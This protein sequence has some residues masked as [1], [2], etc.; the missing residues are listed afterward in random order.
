MSR[1]PATPFPETAADE[2]DTLAAAR[3]G[4]RD[5]QDA[6]LRRHEPW[7]F[8]LA[9]RMVWQRETAEDATQ[10]ILLRAARG[11]PSFSG[12]STFRTWLYRIAVNHLLDVRQSELELRRAT[13]ADFAS[14]LVECAD[15]D[16]PDPST[17]PIDHALLVE[18]A[19][20]GCMT[21]MLMCLDRR[22][23]L[24]FVLGEVFGVDSATGGE[25][26]D[27]TKDHFRQL[28]AR[29]RDDLY[30]FVNGHCGLVDARNPC[31][32]AR[33]ASA[34]R[35]RG[36]LDPHRLQ[37]A[38]GRLDSVRDLAPHRLDELQALDRAHADLFRAVPLADPGD[39][40]AR[41]RALLDASPLADD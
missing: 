22:Q 32:C 33:K 13:F 27:V 14:S 16:L 35:E 10:E 41:L 40:T 26:L 2:N 25:I 38:T 12:K 34:F 5:A 36:W 23:R 39:L 30:Q 21:A 37:F 31:R 1:L 24:A 8:H 28:L 3:T 15:Q 20:L 17:L 18:E 7:V 11:L 6:L 19:K 4:D 29:A 9:L